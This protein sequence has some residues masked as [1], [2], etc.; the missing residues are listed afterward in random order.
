VAEGVEDLSVWNMLRALGC[1]DAQGFF[2]SKPLPSEAL[3]RW[4]RAS[5]GSWSDRAAAL[6]A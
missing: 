1:D 6:R 4:M 5:D 3:A 2:M